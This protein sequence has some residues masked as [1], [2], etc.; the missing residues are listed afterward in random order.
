MFNKVEEIQVGNN[1]R[2]VIESDGNIFAIISAD[3]SQNYQ[4]SPSK[5]SLSLVGVNSASE[6]KEYLGIS[7]DGTWV[8]MGKQEMP[9]LSRNMETI[10]ILIPD[11]EYSPNIHFLKILAPPHSRRRD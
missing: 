10:K 6:M 4:Q 9:F 7:K 2:G 1:K 11:T 8:R 3:Y 5:F